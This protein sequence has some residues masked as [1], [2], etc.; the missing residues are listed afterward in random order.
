MPNIGPVSANTEIGEK[1]LASV[2]EHIL[3]LDVFMPDTALVKKA[4]GGGQTAEK[5][6]DQ[7]RLKWPV[8]VLLEVT[9][10][11]W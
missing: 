3:W 4:N 6:S 11:D 9:L 10:C 1:N 7:R 2:N 5:R 8:E